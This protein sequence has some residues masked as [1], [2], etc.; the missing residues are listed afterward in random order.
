MSLGFCFVVSLLSASPLVCVVFRV[1]RFPVS[2]RSVLPCS[3]S[4][5]ARLESLQVQHSADSAVA[6]GRRIQSGPCVVHS[7]RAVKC[8]HSV[9]RFA[10][11][12]AH[13]RLIERMVRAVGHRDADV[14]RIVAWILVVGVDLVE[15]LAGEREDARLARAED[16]LS[17]VI[18]RLS[19][20]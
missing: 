19:V 13:V 5:R 20:V 9:F 7:L 18:R 17:R 6:L 16:G 15:N 14:A 1:V 3:V 8:C 12:A 4:A 2:F 10:D 11:A